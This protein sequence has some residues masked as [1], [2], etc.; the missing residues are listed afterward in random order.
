MRPAL[1]AWLV[2]NLLGGTGA[3]GSCGE[4]PEVRSQS[5][6][7][8]QLSPE[9]RLSP[10]M[11]G[12]LLCDA[13]HAIAFQVGTGETTGV[14]TPAPLGT[15]VMERLPLSLGVP[16]DHFHSNPPSSRSYGVLEL[17]GEKRLSGPGLPSQQPLSVMVSGG[18][19]PSRLSK[20]CHGY[21]GERGEAQIYGAH[22]RGPAALRQLLCHGDKRPCA[23]RKDGGPD[24]PKALQ[25]EL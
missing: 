5:V 17:D 7:A 21:V 2:L 23:G 10:H 22:R 19:W 18:L 13:C 24:P 4:P 15:R 20:M 11:P 6:S 14:Q 16:S 8:P 3:D 9:E 25:N 1:A 12:S